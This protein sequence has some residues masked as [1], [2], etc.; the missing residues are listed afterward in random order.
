M[1]GV[2]LHTNIVK[3]FN[4][5]NYFDEYF[6]I[7]YNLKIPRLQKKQQVDEIYSSTCHVIGFRIGYRGPPWKPPPG[8]GG[9]PGPPGPMR[10]EPEE[11]S[12]PS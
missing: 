11:D 3:I 4:I 12:T 10:R 8:G 6:N 1:Q 2:Q 7:I 9:P 5:H